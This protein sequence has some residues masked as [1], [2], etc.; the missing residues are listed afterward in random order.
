[1]S[2]T[3]VHVESYQE[4]CERTVQR[5]AAAIF[6]DAENMLRMQKALFLHGTWA[7]FISRYCLWL[8]KDLWVESLS[9]ISGV[10]KEFDNRVS[11]NTRNT[12]NNW[13]IE[14]LTSEQH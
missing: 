12:Q 6:E 10:L 8:V 4:L 14:I 9:L 5:C 13:K 7:A 2:Q 1:M 3:S 11:W